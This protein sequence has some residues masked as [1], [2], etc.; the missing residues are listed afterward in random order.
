MDIQP[1]TTREA[2]SRDV[3][4]ARVPLEVVQSDPRFHDLEWLTSKWTPRFRTVK[5][6]FDL[7]LSVPLLILSLPVLF[8]VGVLIR[9]ESRGPVIYT[10]RRI[11]VDGKRFTIYKLRSMRNDAESA[12][13]SYA[14]Q[15]DPRVTKIGRWLRRT[16]IDE[17]PQLWNV[18]RGDMSIIGPRPERPENEKMLEDA[19]PGFHLRTCIRPGLTGWA[20]IC[21]PYANTTEQSGK[22]LEYDLYYIRN[23]S[24]TL[25]LRIAG[26]TVRV[27]SRLAGQ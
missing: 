26:E 25:D 7:V 15:N 22:K 3:N 2:L 4:L 19:I 12:G 27:M 24:F 14:S 11:G 18:I 20:Q 13:A 10:Q 16:R 17:I 9:I 1:L 21:A 23:V 5:R 8:V 6:A